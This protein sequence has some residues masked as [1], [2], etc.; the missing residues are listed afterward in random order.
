MKGAVPFPPL[1]EAQRFLVSPIS[2][3]RVFPAAANSWFLG[4]VFPF[5]K[6]MAFRVRTEKFSKE[7]IGVFFLFGSSSRLFSNKEFST[8][9]FF[10]H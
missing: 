5:A 1:R 7:G 4:S 2:L 10:M 6:P 8:P 3:C 9:S